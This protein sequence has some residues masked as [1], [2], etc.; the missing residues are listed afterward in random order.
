MQLSLYREENEH[1]IFMQR[2][3]CNASSVR[4]E[5][6]NQPQKGGCVMKRVLTLI[7]ATALTASA[8]M[9][10]TIVRISAYNPF[11]PT[12]VGHPELGPID[13]SGADVFPALQSG[14]LPNQVGT[15]TLFLSVHP[16]QNWLTGGPNTSPEWSTLSFSITYDSNYIDIVLRDP[17]NGNDV[18]LSS[19]PVGAT[20]S[21]YIQ[22]NPPATGVAAGQVNAINGSNVT[23]TF[24]LA[25]TSN[26]NGV[27]SSSGFDGYL[28]DWFR[29]SSGTPRQR[30]RVRVYGDAIAALPNQTYSVSPGVPEGNIIIQIDPRD[31]SRNVIV[32]GRFIVPEPASMIALGSGLVGLLALRRRRSN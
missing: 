32:D 12:I 14:V 27:S 28:R 15:Y 20:L 8:V 7:A 13:L 2:G 11:V 10:Q 18:L 24:A 4:P 17:Q 3:R 1:I 9:A 30:L 31:D 25:A 21:R 6:S 22:A 29:N 23:V 19:L 26:G 16:D 5:L